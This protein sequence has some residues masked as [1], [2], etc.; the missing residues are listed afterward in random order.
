MSRPPLSIAVAQPRCVAY[1]ID[2][3]VAAHA[4]LVR[5]AAARVVVFPELSLT[6][7]ELDAAA[8]DPSDSRLAPLVTVCATLGA[9][10][11]V[12][13]PVAG[14]HIAT[15]AVD[16]AGA[17][18]AYRKMWLGDVEARRFRPGPAPVV[19]DVDG[20]RV[21]LAICKDTGVEEHAA[22]TCAAGVDVYAASIVDSAAEAHVPDQRASRISTTHRVVVAVA[23]FAGAAGGG[24]AETA[25][26]S[27]IWGPDGS[28]LA[29][30]GTAPGE[31]VQATLT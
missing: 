6:G 23:S 11:L 28:V 17:R 4:E 7:Y 3:N 27:A 25:G 24:F 21:G 13:A 5:A 2:A 22:R 20:W 30:A 29:R 8:V 9:L 31:F 16:G 26:R 19:L 15:L 12:G 1:D 10:A 14:E 18:V